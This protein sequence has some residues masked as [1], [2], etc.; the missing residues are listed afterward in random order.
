MVTVE[1]AFPKVGNDPLYASEVNQF[2]NQ[3][4]KQSVSSI[5]Y[6]VGKNYE[7]HDS[8]NQILGFG[9]NGG[10]APLFAQAREF[11][12]SIKDRT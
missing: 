10:E 5:P 7:I 3:S 9:I 4:L 1:G 8:S 2:N 11:Q 12:A 6:D